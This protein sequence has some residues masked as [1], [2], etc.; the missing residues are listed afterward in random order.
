MGWDLDVPN[1]FFKKPK[2]LAELEKLSASQREAMD[3][4]EIEER[5]RN[6][7]NSLAEAYQKQN[8]SGDFDGCVSIVETALSE[9]GGFLGGKMGARMVALSQKSAQN[10]C[11]IYF[12]EQEE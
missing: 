4:V 12:P 11:R 8:A 1:L 7:A 9:T 10:A 2:K 6:V 5:V 3:F